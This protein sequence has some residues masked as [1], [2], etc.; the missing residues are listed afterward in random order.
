[1]LDIATAVAAIALIAALC[2]LA[3]S[4]AAKTLPGDNDSVAARIDALLP[5][6]Q[7]AQCGF[8]GCRPYAD[9]IASGAVDINR[10]P[11]GG[12]GTIL[13]LARLLNRDTVPLATELQP[14]E[15]ASVAIIDEAQCIGCA[16]CL[17]ACPVDAIIGAHPYTHTVV[18][19]LC[20]GCELCIAPCPV[21]CIAMVPV[22]EVAA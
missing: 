10:C 2:G 1:M 15:Q 9:A 11:P 21:D 13:A 16:R 5:Q 12:D 7:C 20:T 4:L 18:A 3:L 17:P 8:A 19:D 14:V 22:D 6:T